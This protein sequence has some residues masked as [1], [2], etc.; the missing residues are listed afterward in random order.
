MTLSS[1]VWLA[2]LEHIRLD[3]DD[4]VRLAAFYHEALGMAPTP[5]D[6]RTIL[7][8]GNERRLVI[9]RGAPGAQPYSA[10]A[11]ADAAR[12]DRAARELAARG[13]PLLPSPTPVFEDGAFAVADPDGRLV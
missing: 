7:L 1:P 4:P 13:V 9:G 12:L 10:F 11:L 6:D 8:Q 2:R 3:S 5:L